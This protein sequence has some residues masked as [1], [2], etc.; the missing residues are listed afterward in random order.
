[1]TDWLSIALG[2]LHGKDRLQLNDYFFEGIFAQIN[3]KSALEPSLGQDTF[4]M[5]NLYLT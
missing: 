5:P 3:H 2:L 1:M 4:P